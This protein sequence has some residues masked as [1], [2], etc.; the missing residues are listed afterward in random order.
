[1]YVCT[2]YMSLCYPQS[3][4]SVRLKLSKNPLISGVAASARGEWISPV[5][6]FLPFGSLYLLILPI[7]PSDPGSF[8]S[9]SGNFIPLLLLF[10]CQQLLP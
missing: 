3:Y 8:L 7:S 1:M 2:F 5:S 4:V 10:V 6:Y 9:I